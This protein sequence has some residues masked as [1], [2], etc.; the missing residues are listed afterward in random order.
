MQGLWFTGLGVKGFESGFRVE[1]EVN[2]LCSLG[3][4]DYGQELKVTGVPRLQENASQETH[5]IRPMRFLIAKKI[6]PTGF[7]SVFL[8]LRK[9][10]PTGFSGFQM[11]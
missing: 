8:F 3:S 10:R 1:V 6:G 7:S 2:A 9:H 5:R 11:K 4:R